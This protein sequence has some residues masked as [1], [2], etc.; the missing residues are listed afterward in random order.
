MLI[1]KSAYKLYERTISICYAAW[2]ATAVADGSPKYPGSLL[3]N[4]IGCG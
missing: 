4:G 3:W 2:A 1:S